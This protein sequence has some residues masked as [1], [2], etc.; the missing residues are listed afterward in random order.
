M[1]AQQAPEEFQFDFSGYDAV[2][3]LYNPNPGSSVGPLWPQSTRQNME[4]YMQSGGG[5]VVIHATDNAFAHWIEFNQM[6]GIGGW[7]GRTPDWGPYI[8]YDN[9]GVLQRDPARHDYRAGTDGPPHEFIVEIRDSTHPIT[10]G[11]PA[12]WKHCMDEIYERLRGPSNN[13]NVLATAY[14]DNV[15]WYHDAT[16]RHEPVMMTINYHLGRVFHTTL[17]H[18]T[19]SLQCV[20]LITM[21]QRGVEWAATGRVTQALPVNFPT[22]TGV[23]YRRLDWPDFSVREWTPYH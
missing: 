15:D 4:H 13:L 23:S 20:G 7:G 16:K 18:W 21:L 12:K 1:R 19:Y 8:Y 22:A 10:A 2:V 17:G 9:N 3:L 6:I 14:S 5:L 11:M